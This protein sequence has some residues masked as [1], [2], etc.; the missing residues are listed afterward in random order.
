MVSLY[1]LYVETTLVRVVMKEVMTMG[2]AA[3]GNPNHRNHRDH[4]MFAPYVVKTPVSVRNLRNLKSVYLM[5]EH[6]R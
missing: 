5:V 2:M 4:P 3:M 1:A 6:E